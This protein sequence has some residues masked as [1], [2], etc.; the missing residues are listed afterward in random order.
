MLSV[1][2][3]VWRCISLHFL[4][5]LLLGCHDPTA[6][7][8]PRPFLLWRQLTM[9]ERELEWALWGEGHP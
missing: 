9:S 8:W 3:V 7:F 1:A 4:P 6:L 5:S 2:Y